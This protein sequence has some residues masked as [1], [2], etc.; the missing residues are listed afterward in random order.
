M[1]KMI[2]E[3]EI[4]LK[5]QNVNDN[6]E[7]NYYFEDIINDDWGATGMI[8]RRGGTAT[9]FHVT[10]VKW[11]TPLSFLFIGRLILKRREGPTY[12]LP[13]IRT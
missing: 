5:V 10:H 8:H 11:L 2:R 12:G 1:P 4:I 7:D 3:T 9:Y 6:H 13:G